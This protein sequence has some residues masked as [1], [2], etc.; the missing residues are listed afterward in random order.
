MDMVK[1]SFA[2]PWVP[3]WIFRVLGPIQA[4]MF[5]ATTA[6]H[7]ARVPPSSYMFG[8]KLSFQ[9][10]PWLEL[11]GS[12]MLESGGEGSP[13]ASLGQRITDHLFF[14]D[15]L[16]PD[17][18]LEISNKIVGTEFKIRIPGAR[19]LQIYGEWAFDDAAPSDFAKWFLR[20]SGYLAGVYLPR[21]DH[22]GRLD[23]SL[24][25]QF[26]GVR[27]YRHAQ[28][29]SGLARDQ[30]LIGSMLG[31]E[32]RAGYL[33]LNWDPLDEHTVS[34]DLAYEGRSHDEYR[35]VSTVPSR[36]EKVRS[37]PQERRYRAVA[38]W[39]YRPRGEAFFL[40]AGAGYE[41]VNTYAF[42]VGR[43]LDNIIGEVRLRWRY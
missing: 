3:P 23:L 26:G 10:A 31:P 42:D 19:G 12:L 11:G 17:E 13:E 4:S 38:S 7:E 25:Y 33:E 34:L 27:M 35:V 37:L 20:D 41:R 8:Y 28:F 21:V 36:I 40:Q 43:N 24:E 18:D 32:A 14:I 6:V 1:L 22:A 2:R 30:R 9:P 5:L 16:V 29:L 15:L 39:S